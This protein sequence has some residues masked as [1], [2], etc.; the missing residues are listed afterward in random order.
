MSLAHIMNLIA[1]PLTEKAMITALIALSTL[2][3]MTIRK[4][5]GKTRRA[6]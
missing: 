2:L 4:F 1:H 5:T 6:P 3:V